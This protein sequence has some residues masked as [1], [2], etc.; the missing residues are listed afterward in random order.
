VLATEG[1]KLPPTHGFEPVPFSR[2]R[3][4]V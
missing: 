3:C 4:S 2:V 1:L